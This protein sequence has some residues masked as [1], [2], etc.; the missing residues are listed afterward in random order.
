MH[1]KPIWRC[2]PSEFWYLFLILLHRIY[3]RLL[4]PKIMKIKSFKN[5]CYLRGTWESKNSYSVNSKSMCLICEKKTRAKSIKCT[6]NKY[7]SKQSN[8]TANKFSF[9]CLFHLISYCSNIIQNLKY[10]WKAWTEKHQC[11]KLLCFYSSHDLV[12]K[13]S[14]V[15]ILAINFICRLHVVSWMNCWQ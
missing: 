4:L 2:I 15:N 9:M 13:S 14:S 12:D 11:K 10:Q 5:T 3:L 7:R 6:A 8:N 1:H